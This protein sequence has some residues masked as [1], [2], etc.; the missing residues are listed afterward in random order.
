MGQGPWWEQGW[1][2][3]E[4]VVTVTRRG[5]EGNRNSLKRIMRQQKPPQGKMDSQDGRSD[6]TPFS[7]AGTLP[8]HEA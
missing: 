1:P 7:W 5:H 4:G 8:A 6:T 2:D 3:M